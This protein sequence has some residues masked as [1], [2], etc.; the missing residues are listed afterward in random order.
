MV[1]P[2]PHLSSSVAVDF[3]QRFA[4][5]FAERFAVGFPERV[6]VHYAQRLAKHDAYGTWDVALGKPEP[7][8]NAFRATGPGPDAGVGHTASDGLSHW[9][10]TARGR[11]ATG[12]S[13]SAA[14]R[15]LRVT[16]C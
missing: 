9:E 3:A 15:L 5:D 6:A 11:C 2:V 14:G 10:H 16:A 13:A 1:Q 4:V 8:L 12:F 7:Q